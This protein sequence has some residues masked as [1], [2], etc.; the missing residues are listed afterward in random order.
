LA[1]SG[2]EDTTWRVVKGLGPNDELVE[3]EVSHQA[4]K[5]D[6]TLPRVFLARA[7]RYQRK[8][9]PRQT[10]LTS[11]LMPT[12]TPPRRWPASTTRDGKSS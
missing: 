11:L 2:E 5:K 9:F 12:A 6:P 4:R 7:I 1:R 8:G 10:L 3:M